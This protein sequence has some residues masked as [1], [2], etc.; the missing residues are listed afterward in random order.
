MEFPYPDVSNDLKIAIDAALKAGKKV[1][2]IYSQDFTSHYKDDKEPLTEADLAS[3]KI[4]HDVISLSS[5]PILSEESVD[6]LDRL[7]S[8]KIWIVD[9]LD[10]T[11]DFIQKTGEFTIMIGLVNDQKPIMGV[12]YWPTKNILYVSE[13]N[14]GAYKLENDIWSQLSVSDE[15]EISKSRVVGSRNHLSQ[16][17][18]EFLDMLKSKQF[19]SKGSSLKAMDISSS[20]SE[21]YFT[22][23][24][25]IKQWDT[26]ASWSI[27]NESG[28]K[29][30][31][32]FGTE[33]QYNTEKIN[34][35][36]GILVTNG[37]IHFSIVESYKQFIN[38]SEIE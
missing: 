2:E 8:K 30:T 33:L 1:L 37:K 34:H 15:I 32:M 9:P 29:M 18:K 16:Q 25:K 23:T 14:K 12:I 21:L 22:T 11:S 3:D 6:N 28:G 4:I 38:T 26:C 13:K 10:G 31:D 7:E 27:V 24:N 17:E 20:L 19:T 35:E 5:Y 36:N